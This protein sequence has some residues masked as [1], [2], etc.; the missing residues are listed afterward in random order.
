MAEEKA[1]EW[2]DTQGL[3]APKPSKPINPNVIKALTLVSELQRDLYALRLRF[4]T[5]TSYHNF[6]FNS[7]YQWDDKLDFHIQGAADVLSDA[8]RYALHEEAERDPRVG[9]YQ[10]EM[11]PPIAQ[12]RK[13][14]Q[15]T[16]SAKKG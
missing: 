2:D 14:T 8:M 6:T 7:F 3:A 16:Q 9:D 10:I 15:V 1:T 4:Q 12:S 13:N 11:P 5:I